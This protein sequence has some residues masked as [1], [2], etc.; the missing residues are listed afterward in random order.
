MAGTSLTSS[1]ATDHPRE[2]EI[3]SAGLSLLVLCPVQDD[4]RM[5]YMYIGLLACWLIGLLACMFQEPAPQRMGGLKWT[6][7]AVLAARVVTLLHRNIAKILLEVEEGVIAKLI[8]L[9]TKV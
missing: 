6:F 4:Y 7:I 3:V 5:T 9:V 2:R 8:P 1:R